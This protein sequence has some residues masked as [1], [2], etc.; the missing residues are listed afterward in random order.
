MPT[1]YTGRKK[2]VKPARSAANWNTQVDANWDAIDL[3]ESGSLFVSRAETP[4][5]SLNVA[6]SA[7]SFIDSAGAVVVYAGTSSFATTLSRTNYLWLT[8]AGVLTEGTAFPSAGTNVVRLAVVVSGATTITS[9]TP[10]R[11]FAAVAGGAA[12]SAYLPLAGGTMTDGANVVLGSTTGTKIGTATTQKLGFYNATPVVQA[13]GTADMGTV[14]S[15][16]GLRATGT[17]PITAGAASFTTLAASG[18]SSLAA[19]ACTTLAPTGSVTIA[20][21]QNII[22]NTTTGTKLG[23]ATSQKLGFW[24]ATPVVQ[25]TGSTDILAGLVTVGLRAAS[26]NPPLNMGSGALTC[27]AVVCTTLAPSSTLTMADA[28][29]IVLNTTTG[30]KL[31]TAVGQKLGFWNATP[32]IQQASANQAALAALTSATLTDSTTGTANTTVMD[33][34]ASHD[35]AILNSNFAD[36]IAQVNAL[37]ADLVA[38]QTLVTAL[39]AALVATGIVKGSA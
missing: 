34:T 13:L 31:G 12:A 3:E 33:V 15:D 17:Y 23:T 9:I 19:V 2:L 10:A 5:A 25:T 11:I 32:V 30:T 26:S 14:L 28:Q 38:T 27:G 24:N 21:A 4:S 16:V 20:D 22:L 36:L 18:A 37:R 8:E 1:T 7:G 6:V 29:N 35:Q 39:R